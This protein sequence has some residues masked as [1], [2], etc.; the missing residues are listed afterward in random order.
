MLLT[1][2]I[3]GDYNQDNIIIDPIKL[4]DID[5]YFIKYGSFPEMIQ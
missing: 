5:K 1:R 2:G 4:R 3:L